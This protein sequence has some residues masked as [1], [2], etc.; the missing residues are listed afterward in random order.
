MPRR[1]LIVDDNIDAAES[2]QMW[3]QIAGHEVHTATDGPEALAAAESVRPEVIL[4]DLGMPGMSGLDVARHIRKAAWGRAMVL[5]ALT[6]WGQDEDRQQTR[7][8]GF[9]HHLT[10]PVPPDEIEELV[11]TA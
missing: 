6:G 11:R 1:I 3:L 8:A 10:K 9:D 2:L 4:L 5:I 7:D